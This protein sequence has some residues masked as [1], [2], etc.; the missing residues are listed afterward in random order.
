[1]IAYACDPCGSGEHWLGWGWA[2]EL[3]RTCQIVLITT[4]K[5]KSAVQ[6]AAAECGIESHFCDVP[7]YVRCFSNLLPATGAWIRKCWW[8]GTAFSLARGLHETE[9]FDV[10]HQTTFHTFRVPFVCSKLNVTSIWGPVAGGESVPRGFD[11]CLGQAAGS[12]RRRIYWN[13]LSLLLPWV[14]TSLNRA[15]SI[16]VS[17]RTTLAF[18][19]EKYHKKCVIVP[20]NA[21]REDDAIAPLPIQK[22]G[23]RFEILFAG[24]CVNTRAM[25]LV[26][27][28]LARGLPVDWRLRIVGSGP[29]IS[30]WKQEIDRNKLG[31]K[32][33]FTGKI[34]QE[35]LR[36]YYA[37]T[38]VLVFPG[39][40]DSGGS[41]L[42]EAM[43]LALPI[44]TFDLGGPG[45][46]VD[47]ESAIMI[48]PLNPD[49]SVA[50]IHAGLFRLATEP[51][52]A[53]LLGQC[54]R[55]R[56]LAMFQW[57]TKCA[58]VAHIYCQRKE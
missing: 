58:A 47:K 33:E 18:L 22:R 51:G 10:V 45:E 41:A 11:R 31:L 35:M 25:P 38:S 42:L 16:L 39:L 54:A 24:N 29:A 50:D 43:T 34:S 6:I 15:T 52:E 32:V 4:S 13:R 49:Q 12:E 7:S 37:E 53:E 9:P 8:Q 36:Q 46:M 21:L 14:R 44:L 5:A 48:R 55:K 57:K 23:G 56:A 26:F 3:S 2:K 30:F 40:R 20:P 19:P 1:M 28:A 27:E 17:N